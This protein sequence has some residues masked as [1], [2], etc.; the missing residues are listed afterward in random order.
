MIDW[1]SGKLLEVT[2]LVKGASV[3]GAII[4]VA[5][6]YYKARSL[7]AL[8]VAAL[9]AGVFLWTINNVDWWQTK[10]QEETQTHEIWNSVADFEDG[11]SASLDERF[12]KIRQGLDERFGDSATTTTSEA[13][14][15]PE[16]P[17]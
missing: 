7:V 2:D 1:L 12:V 4:M 11:V 13:Q 15:T 17:G 8:L 3:L 14:S 5:A 6:A 10:V 9:T 16:A